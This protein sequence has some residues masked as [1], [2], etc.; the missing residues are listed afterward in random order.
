M[1]PSQD[2]GEG[3]GVGVGVGLGVRMGVRVRVRVS[4]LV[5]SRPLSCFLNELE[6]FNSGRKCS[7]HCRVE[8]EDGKYVETACG[9]DRI[10]VLTLTPTTA[11]TLVLTR[12]GCMPS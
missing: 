8:I 10:V 12:D 9:N 4:F 6:R 5:L 2:D 3:E 1:S 11:L 7:R